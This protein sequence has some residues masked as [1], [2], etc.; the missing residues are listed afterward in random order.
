[1]HWSWVHVSG[2]ANCVSDL[3]IHP[4]PP[5]IL[6]KSN[7]TSLHTSSR[8]GIGEQILSPDAPRSDT[9]DERGKGEE[10]TLSMSA[11]GV[12]HDQYT[13]NVYQVPGPEVTYTLARCAIEGRRHDD[14]EIRL[15]VLT[16]EGNGR[17]ERAQPRRYRCTRKQ[18]LSRLPRC[19]RAAA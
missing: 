12:P 18:H 15:Q 8:I 17:R 1:M 14:V 4:R 10:G 19:C 7:V 6:S 9:R 2:S 3:S 13:H 11:L 5:Q 16:T